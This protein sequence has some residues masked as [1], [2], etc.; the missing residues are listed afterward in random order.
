MGTKGDCGDGTLPVTILDRSIVCPMRRLGEGETVEQIRADRLDQFSDIRRQIVRWVQDAVEKLR[1]CD[2]E[3][4]SG[5]DSRA[6]D[7]WRPL[8][9]I[10]TIVGGEW[11]SLA[12]NAARQLRPRK[13]DSRNPRIQLLHDIRTVLE[14]FEK[15]E[16]PTATLLSQLYQLEENPWLEFADG[17]PLDSKRLAA[18]LADF[19]IEPKKIRPKGGGA[20][21][22]GYRRH[23]FGVVFAHYLPPSAEHPEHAEPADH[24]VPGVP[25]VPG[26]HD[27]TD[28]GD[29]SGTGAE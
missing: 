10:A 7:S 2:P 9:G 5:L 13:A 4:P 26:A 21:F 25:D 20:P 22:R 18:L 17:E 3:T 23:D 24:D 11:P 27:N 28:V 8:L 14:K 1:A 6:A 16:I 12:R 29:T 19:G 15:P